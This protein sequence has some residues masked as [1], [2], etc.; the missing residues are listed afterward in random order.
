MRRS[1]VRSSSAPPL[2]SNG[3]YYRSFVF[4]FVVVATQSD[5]YPVLRS[6]LSDE[7]TR[8]TFPDRFLC[9]LQTS[10]SA[11]SHSTFSLDACAHDC[12]VRARRQDR[13]AVRRAFRRS[14]CETPPD[15]THL[16]PFGGNARRCRSFAV[17]GPSFS[18]DRCH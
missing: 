7:V 8:S 16:T 15:R 17:T 18:C 2:S 9:R 12:S 13:S 4:L 3:R 5:S 11:F 14:S 1:G 10:R 6:C